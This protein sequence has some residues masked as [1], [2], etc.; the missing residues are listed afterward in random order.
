MW[1]CFFSFLF[2][3][4]CRLSACPSLCPS[5]CP[6]WLPKSFLVLVWMLSLRSRI[7]EMAPSFSHPFFGPGEGALLP[8]DA[9]VP[10]HTPLASGWSLV[11]SQETPWPLLLYLSFSGE[12]KGEGGFLTP[13][14][15]LP[16]GGSS[17]LA[18]PLCQSL[19]SL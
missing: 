2:Q 8:L 14:A 16:L 4:T 12:A 5:L 13:Q 1:V 10:I 6:L 3:E 11:I 18:L 9:P 17:C 19:L 15:I 7:Q